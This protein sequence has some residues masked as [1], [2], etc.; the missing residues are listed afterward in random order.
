MWWSAI[1][2]VRNSEDIKDVVVISGDPETIDKFLGIYCKMTAVDEF[3]TTME[4]NQNT[5]A[6]LRSPGPDDKT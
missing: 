1:G 4:Y 2:W 5:K 6:R 3:V